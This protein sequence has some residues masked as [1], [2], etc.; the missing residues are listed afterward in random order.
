MKYFLNLIETR[1]QSKKAP[2][3]EEGM[4]MQIERYEGLAHLVHKLYELLTPG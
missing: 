1:M 3:Q 4:R 2:V